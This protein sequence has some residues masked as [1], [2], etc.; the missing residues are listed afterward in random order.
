LSGGQSEELESEIATLEAQSRSPKPKHGIVHETLRS[1]RSILEGA[2][3]G[4]AAELVLKIVSIL[5]G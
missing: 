3:G 2:S 4:V 5:A 1:I